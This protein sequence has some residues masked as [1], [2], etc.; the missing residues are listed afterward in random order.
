MPTANLVVGVVPAL[1]PPPAR[2][3]RLVRRP[4]LDGPWRSCGAV[5]PAADLR[6]R[7]EKLQRPRAERCVWCTL[8]CQIMIGVVLDASAM[9][10]RVAVRPGRCGGRVLRF[11]GRC[12]PDRLAALWTPGPHLRVVS[13]WRLIHVLPGH[14]G[15]S[16]AVCLRRYCLR[17]GGGALDRGPARRLAKVGSAPL[18]SSARPL[19]SWACRLRYAWGALRITY[20]I[21]FP[22][23]PSV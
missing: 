9:C 21:S 20:E 3:A 17:R 6:S 2:G 1:G 16:L 11:P 10:E 5:D 23:P 15:A 18:R 7:V 19:A 12:S 14:A 4:P 8:P 22:E 13:V